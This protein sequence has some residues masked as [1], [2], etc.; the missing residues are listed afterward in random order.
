MRKMPI[1]LR[2]ISIVCGIGSAILALDGSANTVHGAMAQERVPGVELSNADD[3]PIQPIPP[4]IAVDGR[5]AALGE[6]LFSDPLFSRDNSVACV[7]CHN[8]GLGGTDQHARSIG[9]D[10]AVGE[11][12]APTVFNVGFN[13]AQYWDG[14]AATLEDQID[15]PI[16]NP[17]EMGSSWPQVL[18]KI[19]QNPDYVEAFQRIY[20]N[21]ISVASVKDAIATFERSL[22]TPN[23]RFDRYL[24]GDSN[25]IT[26]DEKAGY[27]LFKN[28]GCVACHQ[29]VNVGGNMFAKIGI[30]GEYIDDRGNV[31]KVDFGRYNVT[32]RER[33]RHVF[34]VPSLRNVALTAPYFHDGS[35]ETLDKAVIT[36]AKYQ[37]GR[38]ISDD[39]LRHIVLFLGTLTGEFRGAMLWD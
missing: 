5:K 25:A 15:G 3:E 30:F 12:N 14:R 17:K 38:Q 33:D 34:K 16:N 31:S 19:K 27:K 21:D 26:T 39:D 13:F 24:K 7:S 1:L 22:I 37:L 2:L 9:I 10:G 8:F 28:Y 35:A 18:E 6:M 36:M 20:G 4:T 32:H 29:G 23:S 11:I